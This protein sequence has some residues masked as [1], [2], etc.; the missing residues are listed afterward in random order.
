[1]RS[2]WR[3]GGASAIVLEQHVTN[4][5]GIAGRRDYDSPLVERIAAHV[6]EHPMYPGIDLYAYWGTVASSEPGLSR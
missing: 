4:F 6:G 1:M 5:L 2:K 3:S